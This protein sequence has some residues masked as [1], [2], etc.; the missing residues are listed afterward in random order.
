MEFIL[1]AIV[2]VLILWLISTYNGLIKLRLL[3]KN[4]W[5]DID[6]Q[7]KKRHDLIPNLVN[8]VKGYAAHEQETLEDVIKARNSAV[9][10]KDS[11]LKGKVQAE[12]L[13]TGMIPK[14]FALAE[15]YPDLKANQNFLEL[16]S[17]LSEI[18]NDLSQARRYYNAVVRDF[19]TKQEI[20]PS[21][22]VANFFKFE[23]NP[24]F[25]SAEKEKEVPKVA[26]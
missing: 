5:S 8:I 26:F 1:P 19:N 6:V 12:N 9:S 7:L 24:F 21:N 3:C 17:S 14:I 2:V 11:D 16:Q 20:F 22:I 13:L 25:E 18:E 15:S 4:A 23:Q 10:C